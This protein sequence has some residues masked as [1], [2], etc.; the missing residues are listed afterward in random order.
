MIIAEPLHASAMAKLH[1]VVHV[2]QT[3][4]GADEPLEDAAGE[5]FPTS[6]P[7]RAPTSIALDESAL[8]VAQG[9]KQMDSARRGPCEPRRTRCGW[10]AAR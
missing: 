7:T 4:P 8:T 3:R 5:L 9:N 6:F 10:E 2:L 1:Q